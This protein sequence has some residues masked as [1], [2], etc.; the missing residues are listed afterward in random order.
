M[1]GMIPVFDTIEA[2]EKIYGKGIDVV[3]IDTGE[4][5]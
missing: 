1:E 3:A 5:E 2:A 4:K